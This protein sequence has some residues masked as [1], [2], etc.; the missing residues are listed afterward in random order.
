MIVAKEACADSTR[1]EGQPGIER[2]IAEQV[3]HEEWEDGDGCPR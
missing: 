1:T 3:L 2:G